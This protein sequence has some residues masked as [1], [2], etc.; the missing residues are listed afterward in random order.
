MA[1]MI[2][3]RLHEATVSSAERRVFDIL[4]R[5]PATTDWVVL[6]SLG[7]SHR[8]GRPYG[9]IDFVLLIPQAGVLCLEVKGG[10][11]ACNNGE[12]ETMNR[13]GKVERIRR[14]PFIQARDGMFA[15]RDAITNRAPVGLPSALL[16]AYAVAMPDVS[17]TQS[18]PEWEEWQVLDRETIGRS[19]CTSL[20]RALREQRRLHPRSSP[21]EPTAATM[22]AIQQLIRPDFEVIVS[23][24][25]AIEEAEVQLLRLT[26]EQFEALD[27][28]A[29]NERSLFEGAAGTGKTMLALEFARRSSAAGHRTL[30]ICFNRLLGLWLERQA[31]D[32][33]SLVAG[34]YFKLLREAIT[35]SSI[36]SEFMDA[37]GRGEEP[38]LFESVYPVC[39]RLALEELNETY[40]VL[41]M[42]EAQD[43]LRPAI[44]DV[45]DVWLKGRLSG[46]RWAIFGDFHRQAIFTKATGDT[47]RD[48]LRRSAPQFAR[49]RLTQNCRNTR[50]IGEE[51]ALL[52]GFDSPPY[53]MGQ[54]QGL[55]VDY[56]FYGPTTS[57]ESLLSATVLDLLKDG[58]LPEHIVLLSPNRLS[59]SAAG[60]LTGRT[61]QIVEASTYGKSRSRT[62]AIAFATI[63]TF[64]GMESS[65]V[66]LCDI[67]RVADDVPQSLLYVAM[68]RARSQLIILARDICRAGLA[69]CVRRKVKERWSAYE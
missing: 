5:D 68:S 62:P 30:F 44:L 28:L 69:E 3:A 11:L 55:P 10:R 4:Q 54:V 50:N 45:L 57:Q 49:G 6:H 24:A 59:R 56:R 43:L 48:A 12:W 13:F 37:E 58:V 34:S 33:S 67:E 60:A 40:D 8:Q 64:K 20:L 35:R 61:F 21:G 27:L 47:L 1:R 15:L 7:L 25:A 9:E 2:P 23:R 16:Y 26:G 29:D 46:G 17:F 22:R 14:S 36:A 19:M 31:V 53:K 63:H 41:V 32:A 66:V 51:T 42:D 52:S 18:S 39:G 38:D 65:V